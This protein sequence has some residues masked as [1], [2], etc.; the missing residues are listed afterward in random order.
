MWTTPT[1]HN[2]CDSAGSCSQGG[3][4]RPCFEQIRA[5][6]T[7]VGPICAGI[8]L[9][10][11]NLR[12]PRSG[13]RIQQRSVQSCG[14]GGTPAELCS[15]DLPARTK[16]RTSLSPRSLRRRRRSCQRQ[17]S[18]TSW[19]TSRIGRYSIRARSRRIPSASSKAPWRGPSSR[20]GE[21]QE[22][23]GRAT[24]G[25]LRASS[26]R[27]L[28]IW[29]SERHTHHADKMTPRRAE[30]RAHKSSNNG[31]GCLLAGRSAGNT[32]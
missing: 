29:P 27:S 23:R 28:S 15:K 21:V 3:R 12:G 17:R 7:G 4:R 5:M 14:L 19:G 26:A 24:I 6:S 31:A 16:A 22:S 25:T 2:S 8:H 32:L 9:P 20:G 11:K 30:G 13:T 18:L 1:N 10:S